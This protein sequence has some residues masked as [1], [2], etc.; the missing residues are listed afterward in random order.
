MTLNKL[1]AVFDLDDLNP[2]SE[3]V[4]HVDIHSHTDKQVIDDIASD[5]DKIII[6]LRGKDDS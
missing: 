2:N 3:L 4:F 5:D 6:Y 1:R